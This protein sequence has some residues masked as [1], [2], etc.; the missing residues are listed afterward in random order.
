MHGTTLRELIEDAVDTLV[1]TGAVIAPRQDAEALVA[2]AFGAQPADLP[3]DQ[4][5]EASPAEEFD[6]LVGRRAEGVPLGHLTGSVLLGGVELTVGPGVFVPREQSEAVLARGLGALEQVA[7]PLVVDLC[8]GSAAFALALA[9]QRLDA[10]V[11]AVECDPVAL[12]FARRNSERQV[13]L[14][15]PAIVLHQAD[16]ADPDLLADLAGRVDLV[17]ANPP[18][19]PEEA[20]VPAEFGVHQPR[21]AVF[22][23]PDGLRVIRQT[24][25]AAARLLAPGAT[26]VLEHGHLHA[27]T[28]PAL[29]RADNRFE[30]VSG[31]LDQYGWPLFAV[32]T[33]AAR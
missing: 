16:V 12:D 22:A 4:A 9:H 31:H 5:P 20:E 15:E 26:L 19:M 29:L 23:G 3:L 28:V 2:T 10:T 14:G 30:Q 18:F 24:I 25:E 1:R 21:Q 13:A 8:A 17:L 27:E 7:L 33:R 32:A 11:H 6:R